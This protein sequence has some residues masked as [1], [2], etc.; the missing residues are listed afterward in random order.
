MKKKFVTP[1]VLAEASNIAKSRLKEE[2]FSRFINSSIALLLGLGEEYIEKN[3]ILK[4]TELSKFGIT[5]TS[6]ISV[7]ERNKLLLTDDGPLFWYCYGCNVP[8]VHLDNIRFIP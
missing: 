7:T 2:R 4:R 8:T 1:Q 3:E 5:D 6:L